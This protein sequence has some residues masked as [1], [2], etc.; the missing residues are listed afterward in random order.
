RFTNWSLSDRLRRISIPVSVAY[1]TDPKRV[2]DILL[3]V[4]RKHPAVLARPESFA[5]FDRFSDSA[6][7][8][9]LY[10]WSSVDDWFMVRSELSVA[11]NHAFTEAGIAIPF[12]QQDVHLH[13]PDG[14]GAAAG[15]AK[16]AAAAPQSKALPSV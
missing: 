15:T 6:L 8:F 1:G 16:S 3:D 13:W 11:I 9:T 7:N 12:P 4:A 10:C 2:I 14:R 5:V